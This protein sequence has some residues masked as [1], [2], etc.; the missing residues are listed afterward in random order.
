MFEHGSTLVSPFLTMIDH[1]STMIDHGTLMVALRSTMDVDGLSLARRGR[2]LNNATGC[3][4]KLMVDHVQIGLTDHFRTDICQRAKGPRVTSD[5]LD[6]DKTPN[7]AGCCN[8]TQSRDRSCVRRGA[9]EKN[10]RNT[11][12]NPRVCETTS[13]H[14]L[15]GSTCRLLTSLTQGFL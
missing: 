14:S 12:H 5:K 6:A 7:P 10:G 2:F 4:E 9:H 1:R 15:S 13:L 8:S 11:S 3:N